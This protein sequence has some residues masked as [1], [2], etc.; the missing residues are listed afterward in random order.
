M[1]QYSQYIENHIYIALTTLIVDKIYVQYFYV[2]KILPRNSLPF[3][4]VSQN[5]T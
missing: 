3:L 2:S 1:G 5:C 4:G